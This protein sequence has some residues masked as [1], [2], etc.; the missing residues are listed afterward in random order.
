MLGIIREYDRNN[1]MELKNIIIKNDCNFDYNE[2]E[3]SASLGTIYKHN[4]EDCEKYG[5][6]VTIDVY[7]TCNSESP[8]FHVA[9]DGDGISI[10]DYGDNE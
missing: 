7:K 2:A 6:F 9:I 1:E 3:K 8:M 4:C 5:L 10:D